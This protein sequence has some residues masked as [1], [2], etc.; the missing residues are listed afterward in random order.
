MDALTTALE[1]LR[2][3]QSRLDGAAAQIA[4]ATRPA[5]NTAPAD[6]VDLSSAM[7]ELIETRTAVEANTAV[8]K[9]AEEMGKHLVD[10]LG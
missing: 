7:V 1:G 2:M 10:I 8:T 4:R 6:E 9:T 3:A 5:P